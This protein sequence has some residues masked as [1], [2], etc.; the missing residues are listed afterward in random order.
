MSK[1]ETRYIVVL[2]AVTFLFSAFSVAAFAA[3]NK[4]PSPDITKVQ[5]ET[6][7]NTDSNMVPVAFNLTWRNRS[8][9]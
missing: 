8:A 4:V 9:Q 5:R 6:D 7:S 3:T 1:K 2:L